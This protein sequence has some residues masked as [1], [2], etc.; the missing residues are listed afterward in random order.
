MENILDKLSKDLIDAQKSKDAVTVS[1]LRLLFSDIKNAQIAKGGELTDG[2]VLN[3]ITKS[4]KKRKE[5]IDAYN[6]AK[7]SDLVEGETQELSVLQ[8]YLPQQMEKDE[9]SEIIK[10]VISESDANGPG[11][12]GKVIGQVMAKVSG[13]ADGSIVSEI[14]K[15]KLTQ[16]D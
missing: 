12:V 9:I 13:R 6:K 4:A 5:S 7:R 8:K 10:E 14:V 2:E 11:D 15:E 1:T 16:S 3:Q